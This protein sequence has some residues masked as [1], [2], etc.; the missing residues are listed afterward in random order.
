MQH[1]DHMRERMVISED[2]TSAQPDAI[3]QDNL[4][5]PS[6]TPPPEAIVAEPNARVPTRRYPDR[7]RHP[8]Q[9]LM[10]VV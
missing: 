8:P 3:I 10:F 2:R 4:H 1:V 6:P 9:R 7:D 5:Y